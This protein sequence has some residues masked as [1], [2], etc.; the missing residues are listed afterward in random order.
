MLKDTLRV[1]PC[2]LPWTPK[3][4]E[5]ASA[6]WETLTG[7]TWVRRATGSSQFPNA[8]RPGFE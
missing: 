6:L 3:D 5:D 2:T 4:D 1:L 7:S 8:K